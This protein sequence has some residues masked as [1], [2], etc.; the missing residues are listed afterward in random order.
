MTTFLVVVFVL[1]VVIYFVNRKVMEAPAP[2]LKATKKVEAVAVKVVDVN[3][4]G[5]VDLKDAVAAVKA[6]EA[7][8]KKVVKKAKKITTKKKTK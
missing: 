1:A 8:G 4:D 5:K 6:V 2:L 3:G 7:T